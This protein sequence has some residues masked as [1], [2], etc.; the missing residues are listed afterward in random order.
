MLSVWMLIHGFLYYNY[1]ICN[2]RTILIEQNVLV[3]KSE[4]I[5]TIVDNTLG[6]DI[7]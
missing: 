6:F 1:F 2:Y 4:L 5:V 3:I 7:K